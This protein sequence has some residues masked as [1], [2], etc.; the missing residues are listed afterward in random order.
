Q[1]R[2]GAPG[3]G[4][5]DDDPAG[6]N[7]RDRGFDIELPSGRRNPLVVSDHGRGERGIEIDCAAG[8]AGAGSQTT[9]GRDVQAVQRSEVRGEAGRYRRA[10]FES[11]REGD[12][13]VCR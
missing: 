11:A 1:V 12:R 5:E 6:E 7:R 2:A 13:L 10:L 4:S 8:V 3:P 9:P